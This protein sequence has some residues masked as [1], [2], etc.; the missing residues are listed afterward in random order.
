M[1]SSAHPGNRSGTSHTRDIMRLHELI[2]AL[3]LQRGSAIA[4]MRRVDPLIADEFRAVAA[5]RRVELMDLAADCL[6]QLAFDAAD[7]VWQL[8]IERHSDASDDPEAALLGS[9]LRTAIRSRL[10]REKMIGSEMAVQTVFLEFR[11]LGHPYS[12]A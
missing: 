4:L 11:R 5:H 8:G 12:R 3:R 2:S 9:I 7:T 1:N 6:E 10:R